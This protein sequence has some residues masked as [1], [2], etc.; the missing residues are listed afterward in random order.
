[1]KLHIE[2]G[3]TLP[4]N[5]ALRVWRKDIE[6][7]KLLLKFYSAQGTLEIKLL[8]NKHGKYKFYAFKSINNS[9]HTYMVLS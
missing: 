9:K 2:H 1:M 5:F 7:N 4:Q 6:L 3:F 8:K